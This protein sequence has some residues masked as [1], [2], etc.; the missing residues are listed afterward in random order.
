MIQ[1]KAF[2]ELEIVHQIENLFFEKLQSVTQFT[3]IF[4]KKLLGCIRRYEL[5]QLK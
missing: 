3:W 5:R 1:M 4:K 2:C